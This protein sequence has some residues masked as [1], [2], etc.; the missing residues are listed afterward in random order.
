MILIARRAFSILLAVATLAATVS[1][2][3]I[4]QPNRAI[5]SGATDPATCNPAQAVPFFR[6]TTSGI[7]KFCSATNTWTAIGTGGGGSGTVTSVVIAGTGNQITATGTCTVTTSGTCTF[8]LPSGLVLP[9]TINGITLTTSTGTIT[10]TNGKTFS[11]LKTL[12][13]DGTD[14]VTI[15]F[16]A[17]SATVATLGLTN[18]FTGRQDASGAAST[19]PSKVGTTPPAT[20]TLGDQFF[21][22]DATAGSN[23]FGCTATNTWTVQ[24]G[25]AGGAPAFSAVTPGTNTGALVI[26]SSGTLATSGTGSIS[27]TKLT[28]TINVV[29]G[30]DATGVTDSVAAIQSAITATPAGG[31]LMFPANGTFLLGSQTVQGSVGTT[32]SLYAAAG[33]NINLNGSTLISDPS[34]TGGGALCLYLGPNYDAATLYNM[35]NV[36]RGDVT[37]TLSTPAQASN[38]TSGDVV[39]LQGETMDL[40][41][42]GMNI[43]LSANASTG[44]LTLAYPS[45]QSYTSSPKIGD[46]Q[47]RTA[48][49]Y[50]IQNGTIQQNQNQAILGH[51]IVNL[52]IRDMV[53]KTS[54]S[55]AVEPT[56]LNYILDSVY[57]GNTF[58]GNA[59]PLIDIMASSTNTR[60]VGNTL[61]LTPD[62]TGAPPTGSMLGVGEGS[63]R[64]TVVGNTMTSVGNGVASQ[65]GVD[66]SASFDTVLDGN[67]IDMGLASTGG[68]VQTNNGS[69][70]ATSP[71]ISNNFIRSAASYALILGSLDSDVAS[72]NVI[73]A[74][75]AAAQG[76]HVLSPS[77][78]SGGSISI[79][80]TGASAIII[81]GTTAQATQVMGVRITS[82]SGGSGVLIGDPGSQQ[83]VDPTIVGNIFTGYSTPVNFQTAANNIHRIVSGNQ[84]VADY[85]PDGVTL[86]PIAVASL[87]TCNAAAEGMRRSVNNSNAASFTLGIG[88]VVAAGGTTH[89]PVFCDGTSWR[90]G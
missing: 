32:C 31:T 4:S 87:P 88:A 52:I 6:N 51:Q 18:T 33:I 17:S 36:A 75:G 56:Q 1:A 25:G 22:S 63:A 3:R 38:F 9:G 8:S 7:T 74:T 27:A 24:T 10:L 47:A 13:F 42:R 78:I 16:P 40:N 60:V 89:V 77:V 53:V 69:Y 66:L 65:N 49:N 57:E 68:A 20:C 79:A 26:G 23:L 41:N 73:V 64:T 76:I 28:N 67:V 72:G 70:A 81:E 39:Y 11:V 54:T 37:V 86:P 21:D 30:A 50:T 12:T 85:L 84:G 45:A 71:V 59:G 35:S 90:I 19:A 44:V 14:G 29:T 34:L 2:Q 43:V 80:G 55:P 61:E 58:R 15:T 82:A 83:A 5:T 46:V 48:F 62:S